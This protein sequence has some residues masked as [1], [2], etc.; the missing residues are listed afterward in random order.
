MA[1]VVSSIQCSGQYAFLEALLGVVPD[2]IE[3][4]SPD[5]SDAIPADLGQGP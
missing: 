4:K 3:G 5:I 2:L 1:T